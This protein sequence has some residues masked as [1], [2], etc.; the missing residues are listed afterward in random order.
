VKSLLTQASNH[1]EV[2]ERHIFYQTIF[3]NKLAL[4]DAELF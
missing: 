2:I 1:F 3:I 4:F